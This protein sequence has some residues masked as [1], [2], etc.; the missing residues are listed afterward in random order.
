MVPVPGYRKVCGYVPICPDYS[1]RDCDRFCWK[2]HIEAG[3][4]IKVEEP[5]EIKI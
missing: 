1:G 2:E 4:I 5:K 3:G